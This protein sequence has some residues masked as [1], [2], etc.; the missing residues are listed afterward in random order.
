[1]KKKPAMEK[2]V[3]QYNP[4]NS[5]YDSGEI[6]KL[7]VYE[8][9]MKFKLNKDY[10]YTRYCL[11]DIDKIE[12]KKIKESEFDY[13]DP[14]TGTIENTGN[15]ENTKNNMTEQ[16]NTFSKDNKVEQENTSNLSTKKD[17]NTTISNSNKVDENTTSSDDE[18]IGKWN[19]VKVIDM[20]SGESY[21][22][23]IEII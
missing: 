3:K 17:E 11:V 15:L 4:T 2:I 14:A 9:T 1:M 19:T 22:N 21:D 7:E 13:E 12:Y 20:Q 8:T 18:L 5:V 10:T 16:S 23:L 6:D